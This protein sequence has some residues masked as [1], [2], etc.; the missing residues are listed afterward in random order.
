MTLEAFD[1][2]EILTPTAARTIGVPNA[3]Y[4]LFKPLE[5]HP[6]TF[7][8]Y[9]YEKWSDTGDPVRTSINAKKQHVWASR[10]FELPAHA[11]YIATLSDCRGGQLCRNFA[12]T[13]I[14]QALAQE[15][16]GSYHVKWVRLHG[17]FDFQVPFTSDPERGITKPKL[18]V[19]DNVHI[20]DTQVKIG[21]LRD[22]LANYDDA[23]VFIILAEHKHPMLLRE[24]HQIVS[25]YGLHFKANYRED[26]EV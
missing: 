17:G 3:A 19:L 8:A 20:E 15:V 7:S 23:H 16:V 18:L 24:H 14:S 13:V 22:I 1:R 5:C 9:Q 25:Q 10:L 26:A 6:Q 21:K 4:G 11:P 12:Q 2:H